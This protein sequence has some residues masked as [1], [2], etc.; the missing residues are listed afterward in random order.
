MDEENQHTHLN[1]DF[2]NNSY[3]R[4]I[5]E[6]S[7]NYILIIDSDNYIIRYINK[8]F[9][10]VNPSD[11]LGKSVFDFI[12]PDYVELYHQK[13]QEVKKSHQS[14][15][16]ETI[17]KSSYYADN[18]AWYRTQLS[19]IKGKDGQVEGFMV[20][21]DDIT[22]HKVSELELSNKSERIKA[23]INNTNDIIC[24]IDRD[25]NIT[26][27]NSVFLD[28]VKR[29]YQVDLQ[30]G[31]PI[32]QFIDPTKHDHLVAIY[33]KALNGEM[34]TDIQSFK[35]LSGASMY[36][37]TNYNPI[38]DVDKEVVGINIFSKDITQRIKNEQKI[39][40][41]LKEKEVLLAEV[42]HRIKNNLAMVSSLLQLQEMNITNEEA[43]EALIL[44]RKRIKST[45]L[46]HE[47]LYRSESFQS[48]NVQDYLTELFNYLKIDDTIQLQLNGDLVNINL[49]TALPLGLMLN[50][51]MLNSFKHSYK[52]ATEGITKIGTSLKQNK[53]SIEYCDCKGQFPDHVDF[54]NSNTTGLTLIH[55][56]AEQLNGSIE[57]I[58]KMPPKYSIQIPLYEEQ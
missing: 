19:V 21:A 37:E 43:K 34:Y 30:Y 53:L 12:L 52:G 24:S 42:H 14:V 18:K 26:E 51:I 1:E 41:A 32:L 6:N 20:I 38:Y 13:L 11:V 16:I 25:L 22:A 36:N 33:K 4:S 39:K 31:M 46:I 47:L 35:G 44:S 9:P 45:A 17:G 56:F 50:E 10:S 48:I 27:Y 57:L 15:F 28:M 3:F 8:L 49:S 2:L 7:I 5:V 29:G 55:T 54:K 58:S 23:I 40:N